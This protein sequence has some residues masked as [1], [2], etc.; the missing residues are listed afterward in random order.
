MSLGMLAKLSIQFLIS[1]VLQVVV[2]R[3]EVA[4]EQ[5]EHLEILQ[6]LFFDLSVVQEEV[7]AHEV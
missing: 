2:N 5:V 3:A 4:L 7:E 6:K 1:H